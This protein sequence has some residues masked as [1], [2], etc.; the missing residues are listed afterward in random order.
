MRPA[1]GAMRRAVRCPLSVVVR[2]LMRRASLGVRC[3]M[4]LRM[5]LP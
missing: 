2:R 1:T 4:D 5:S 3:P